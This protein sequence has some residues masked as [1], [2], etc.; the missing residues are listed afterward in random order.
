MGGVTRSADFFYVATRTPIVF[1][2]A[3]L[4]SYRPRGE[5]VLLDATTTPTFL[6]C[7]LVMVNKSQIVFLA[8]IAV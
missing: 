7:V 2:C 6:A 3:R 1:G 4:P 5:H 8:D